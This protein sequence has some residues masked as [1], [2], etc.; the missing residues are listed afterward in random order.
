MAALPRL[1]RFK[2]Y[3]EIVMLADAAIKMNGF[4]HIDF[5]L[6]ENWQRAIAGAGK[7]KSFNRTDLS[8]GLVRLW[9]Y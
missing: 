6:Y 3:H 9:S 2:P 7:G 4:N 1:E 8:V 5:P